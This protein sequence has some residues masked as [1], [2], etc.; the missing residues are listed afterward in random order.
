VITDWGFYLA[1]IPAVT[2][3]GLSKGG[4]AAVG[5]VAAPLLAL[6]AP[7]LQAAVI[8]LPILLIQDA[9]S[10]WTYRKDWSAWNLKVLLPGALIGIGA[11]WGLAAHVSDNT[12]RLTVGLIGLSFALYAWFG[13]R[14]AKAT[15]P[16]AGMGVFWGAMAGFTSTLSQAGGPPFQVYVLP[17]RLPKLTF[18]GTTTL[19]FATVN[20]LKLIPYTALGQFSWD[21]IG[22]SAVL[23]PIAVLTNFLGIWLVRVTPTE[24]LYRIAYMMMFLISLGLLWQGS[25]AFR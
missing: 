12:V 1:A 18:V 24:L 23:L 5:I 7:P 14:R 6:Y 22:T 16:I 4:F 9:I 10:I 20:A 2:F 8:L 13:P 3:L 21:G 15:D 25:A 19:F 11:A 17:Q